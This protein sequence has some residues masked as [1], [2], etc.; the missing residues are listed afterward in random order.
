M[1]LINGKKLLFDF[2]AKHNAD[3]SDDTRCD[4][5]KLLKDDLASSKRTSYDVTAFSH[6]DDDHIHGASEF[7]YLE[8]A[9]KYQSEDRIKMDE[10]WVP[11]AAIIE[12]GCEDEDRI[13]RAEARYRLLAGKGI[14]VFSR[15]EALHD[16][17]AEHGLTV[18]D[19]RTL[20][21]DAGQIVPGFTKEGDGVE[22]FAH[23]PFASR[24]DDGSV[25]DRNLDALALQATFL[26]DR[27]E[28]KLILSSDLDHEC[29]KQIVK[30]TK[31]KKNEVRL[32][33][34]IFKLPHHCS[35]TALSPDKGKEK[36]IPIEEVKWLFET[37][38][39]EKGIVISTSK[40]IPANDDD[41]QPPHRQAANYYKDLMANKS[42][43]FKVTMEH[44]S[45]GSPEPLVIN[46]D[47]SKATIEKRFA[48]G[49]SV[50]TSRPSRAGSY[51]N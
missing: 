31:F 36:T 27:I 29:F 22:F 45:E 7:F 37:Q 18:E 2:A 14:R 49:I 21:T 25:L 1:D 19:R 16:W 24:L 51:G 12:E 47:G 50:I 32:E 20:F 15:P 13:I 30:I 17:L 40:P 43:N 3:D 4:L 10:L 5:P 9:E 8:H 42:G 38:G 39:K 23:S 11:A 28:T 44:P 48:S 26:V 35:Y 41:N 34:D 46:I 33:W 6:L